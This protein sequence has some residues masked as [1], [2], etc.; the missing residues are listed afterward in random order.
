MFPLHLSGA[1]DVVTTVLIGFAFGFVLEKAGFGDSR[2]L[3]AQ[4]Y[5]SD[6]RVLKVMFSAIV[7]A[8]LLVFASSA[9]GWVDFEQI[10]V[11]PTYLGASV[12]GGAAL[13]LGFIIGGY[14][15]GTSLVALATFKWD[16]LVFA[17]GV[18]CGMF[19]FGLM[20]PSLMA[21]WTTA[22][23][24]DR[25]TIFEWLGVDAGIVVAAV[26]LMAI[27]AFFLAEIAEARI[28]WAKPPVS[29][30]PNSPAFL[31]TAVAC[32][33]AA[34][35]IAL[36]LGQPDAE[37]KIAWNRTKLNER[38]ES[39]SVLID[40]AELLDLMYNNQVERLLLDVRDESDYNAFHLKDA[41]RTTIPEIDRVWA[42]KIR[43]EQVVVVMSNDEARAV[44]AWKH[45]AVHRAINAYILAGGVNRWCEIYWAGNFEA[46]GPEF[47][48][49]GDDRF[50]F[51]DDFAKREQSGTPQVTLVGFAPSLGD[52]AAAARPSAEYLA[53]RKFQ[54]KIRLL[55]AVKAPGGGCGG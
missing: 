30:R 14:C 26:L 12:A 10:F 31:R 23:A 11:P 53:K 21:F 24:M 43:P 39:R 34:A 49:A 55:R 7:T 9:L 27:G 2:N 15:P 13:G 17:L 35:G 45:L 3:A 25:I 46:P 18:A 48:A 44:E 36:I 32:G 54:P 22:G 16:G 33:I 51:A 29:G 8:M 42:K 40:P 19:L 1:I 4:F 28:A 20:S 50:R 6:L 37:R 41:I 47:P 38:L 52:R 5:L